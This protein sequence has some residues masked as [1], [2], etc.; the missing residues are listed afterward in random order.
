MTVDDQAGVFTADG[1]RSA[2]S[3]FEGV[4]FKAKTHFTVVTFASAPA[5]K[6]AELDATKGDKQKASRFFGQWAKELAGQR[7]EKG[8]FVLIYSE[9][10]K[11]FVKARGDEQADVFRSFNDKD[12]TAIEDKLVTAFREAKTKTGD[13]AKRTRDGG[14]KQAA[15]VVIE[16]LRETTVPTGSTHSDGSHE[17]KKS[18]GW[19]IW[20]WV[21]VILGVL[22][23]IWIVIALI[24]AMTG[25]VYGGMYG[26][27]GYGGYGGG[28]GPGFFGMFMGGM[29]GSMAGM[30]LYNSMMGTHYAHDPSMAAGDTGAA[31]GGDVD[32]DAGAGD[33]DNGS[34]GA[35]GG[36]WGDDGGTAAG[37]GGGGDWGGDGGGGDWG[38]DGGGGDWGGGGDFGGG[39]FGGGGD[40]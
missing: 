7:G 31:D 24:R 33:F 32:P 16:E 8:V 40:W 23:V 39:D 15:Q 22:L 14:L 20:L 6:K 9:G 30:W 19:P 1:V 28:G 12:A 37:D 38:G 21:V 2:E 18:G 35:G 25:N 4:L 29:L 13:E 34:E 3:L 17:T 26:G 36:D 10:D 11:F 5:D 27:G